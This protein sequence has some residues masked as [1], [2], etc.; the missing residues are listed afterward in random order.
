MSWNTELQYDDEVNSLC[1]AFYE[2]SYIY[3]FFF[4]INVNLFVDS[5]HSNFYGM[6]KKNA[7]NSYFSYFKIKVLINFFFF[8]FIGF[9]L[10]ALMTLQLVTIKETLYINI[11]KA[12]FINAMVWKRTWRLGNCT[13]LYMLVATY[14]LSSINQCVPIP[15]TNCSW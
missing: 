1:N 9:Y 15:S 3:I 11:S 12:I 10:F 8:S 6:E 13:F 5:T 4:S 7:Q 2:N 14:T